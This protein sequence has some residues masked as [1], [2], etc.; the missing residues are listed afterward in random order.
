MAIRDPKD[1]RLSGGN[2]Y[3]ET[4]IANTLT[5]NPDRE[6]CI[7]L[8]ACVMSALANHLQTDEIELMTR[9]ANISSEPPHTTEYSAFKTS[10]AHLLNTAA[11]QTNALFVDLNDR[12]K[13]L[14]ISKSKKK[15]KKSDGKKS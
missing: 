8:V 10:I 13:Q 6:Q 4:F 15:K 5:R 7:Q 12:V 11:R 1:L 3:V 9:V 14:E 2:G